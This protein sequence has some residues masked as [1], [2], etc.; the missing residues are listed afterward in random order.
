MKSFF[1]IVGMAFL[2][3]LGS[4]ASVAQTAEPSYQAAPDVYKVILEDSNYRVIEANH[5]KGVVTKCT[6]TPS[7][8]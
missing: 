6:V 7:R 2:A 8:S 1:A 4:S 3:G 5:K